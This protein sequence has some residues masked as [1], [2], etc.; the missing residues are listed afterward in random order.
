MNK[1][2]CLFVLALSFLQLYGQTENIRLSLNDAIQIGLKNNPEM[3]KA[4][5]NISAAGGRFWSGISFP[6]P[7]L[8]V[9]Y[10]YAP[11]NTSL[12]NYSEKTL[13]VRQNFEFPSNYFLRGNKL[14]KEEEIAY[15]QLRQTGLLVTSEIK[16]A[17]CNVLAKQEQVRN[18]EENLAIT[19]DFSQKAEIRYNA[20]EGTN[21]ERLTAKVQFT[22]T[23]NNLEAAKNDL[24][25][26][27]A[28]LNF[29]LGYGE[30]TEVSYTL[31]D[32]MFFSTEQQGVYSL[33][34]LHKIALSNNQTIKIS[35]LKECAS[36]IDH[37][38][39]WSSLLPDFNIGYFRQSRDGDN[40]Y[41]GASFGISLPLWFL[42]DNRGRIQ[43][44][45]ANMSIALSE[46]Q[47]AKNEVYL[48]LKTAF[49]NY[50]KNLKQVR[51]YLNHILPQAEEVYRSATA[52]YDA[53]EITYLEFLQARQIFINAKSNY[54]DILLSYNL[55]IF[56]IEKT[57]GQSL[58]E[59]INGVK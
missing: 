54:T 59:K 45:A 21:I 16:S 28:E 33:E 30:R 55:S 58:T 4:S 39:A 56:T 36:S 29:A 3:K 24:N 48:K 9:S 51:L 40:G 57:V 38:L 23:E 35:E 26:A 15:Y 18:A 44:A 46:L 22:Q 27:F 37:S 31:T 5:D 53:G 19:E 52:S 12:S 49:N 25:T 32:S 34:E 43:E 42:F 1:L 13:E 14:S 2:L 10:E 11:V 8:G 6:K 50:E 47:L 20:G 17:Y 7:E 41:Y